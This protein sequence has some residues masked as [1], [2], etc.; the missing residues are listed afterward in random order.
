VI[1]DYALSFYPW[2]AK[3]W[4]MIAARHNAESFMVTK[5]LK[6]PLISV[7]TRLKE[8]TLV[9]VSYKRS[10]TKAL[11]SRAYSSNGYWF[12]SEWN[13]PW[14]KV[15]KWQD[16]F[17]DADRVLRERVKYEFFLPNVR[18]KAELRDRLEKLLTWVD[19]NLVDSS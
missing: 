5:G 8:S 1:R 4:D 9:H 15:M 17:R 7:Q 10:H 19:T 16:T 11:E 2:E 6:R 18:S 14:G 3:K 12:T 13:E